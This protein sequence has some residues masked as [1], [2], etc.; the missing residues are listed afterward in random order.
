[1]SH[2]FLDSR[3]GVVQEFL[4]GERGNWKINS[5]AHTKEG[6]IEYYVCPCIQHKVKF[7]E[8][9]CSKKHLSKRDETTH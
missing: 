3:C 2:S 6:V 8:F 7:V 5:R 1:M 9:D 4:E